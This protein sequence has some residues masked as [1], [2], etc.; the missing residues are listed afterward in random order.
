MSL[1]LFLLPQSSP[2]ELVAEI[3]CRVLS[4][5]GSFPETIT[6]LDDVFPSP[7]EAF[8]H[9]VSNALPGITAA[10]AGKTPGAVPDFDAAEEGIRLLGQISKYRK[11]ESPD[12]LLEQIAGK[13]LRSH[14]AKRKNCPSCGSSIAV[15]A[16]LSRFSLIL[17]CPVCGSPDFVFPPETL[18]DI[19]QGTVLLEESIAEYNRAKKEYE[20]STGSENNFFWVVAIREDNVKH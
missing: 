18:R 14:R 2:E 4:G 10:R 12:V 6:V 1:F 15:K 20:Y 19:E 13:I 16:L 3:R 7:D 5:K 11:Y 17:S 8:G 9:F